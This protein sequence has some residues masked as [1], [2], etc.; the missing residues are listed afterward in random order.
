MTVALEKAEEGI[1]NAIQEKLDETSR[2]D[3][4][5]KEELKRI[6]NS[7]QQVF[8]EMPGRIN[9]YEHKL[10]IT[11]TTPYCLKGW[12]VPL[13]YQNACLLYTSRCV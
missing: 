9:K 5:T 13:K 10:K 12:P 11:D 4:K 8:R 6:L 3:S 2:I 1:I 7:N